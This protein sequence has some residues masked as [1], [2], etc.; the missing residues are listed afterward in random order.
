MRLPPEAPHELV[1]QFRPRWRPRR[2]RMRA[3][4][5]DWNRPSSRRSLEQE[6]AARRG[7]APEG[8]SSAASPVWFE[9]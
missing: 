3:A 7:A 6:G 2:E 8:S 4:I 9:R 1:A 5:A